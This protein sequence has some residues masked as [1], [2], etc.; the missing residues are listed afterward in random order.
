MTVTSSSTVG[1]CPTTP[2]IMPMSPKKIRPMHIRVRITTFGLS[3]GIVRYRICWKRLAP[4]IVAA[5]YRLPSKPAM[6][7]M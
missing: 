7:A 3:I 1:F 4:S 5:S 6:A 2:Q